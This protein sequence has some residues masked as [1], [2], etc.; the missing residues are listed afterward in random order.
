MVVLSLALGSTYIY[1]YLT[2]MEK[3]T[4]IQQ[5]NAMIAENFT[6]VQCEVVHLKTIQIEEQLHVLF[7]KNDP[8][9]ICSYDTTKEFSMDTLFDEHKGKLVVSEDK[10]PTYMAI[11]V[12]SVIIMV[13]SFGIC[14]VSSK[15][16][17]GKHCYRKTTTE[18]KNKLSTSYSTNSDGSGGV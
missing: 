6:S 5:H 11:I 9:D 17:F 10:L 12:S 7:N 8:K 2:F 15:K 14:A 16:L 3:Y 13:F 4:C 1:I 18:T